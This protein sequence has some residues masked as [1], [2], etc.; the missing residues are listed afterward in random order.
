MML[1]LRIVFVFVRFTI[2]Y[3]DVRATLQNIFKM[4]F[5]ND[6]YEKVDL[7]ILSTAEE[8]LNHYLNKFLVQVPKKEDP[9][10]SKCKSCRF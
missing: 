3:H 8:K 6:K 2:Q 9:G 7:H 10:L 1:D 5:Y 4:L